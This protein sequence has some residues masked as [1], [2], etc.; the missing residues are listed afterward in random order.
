[1]IRPTAFILASLWVPTLLAAQKPKRHCTG[2]VPDS[3][4]QTAGPVYRDCDVDQPAELRGSPPRPEMA[5]IDP[6][7]VR[8]GCLRAEF[9]FIVDTLGVPEPASIRPRAGNDARFEEAARATID[10]LRYRSARLAGNPVRQLVV[11]KSVV[12]VSVQVIGPSGPVGLP[13]A[14]PPRCG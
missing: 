3:S 13:A 6:R 14:R 9:E 11:Y 5:T 8:G 7:Q 4:L 10:A 2:T 12:G 1:M